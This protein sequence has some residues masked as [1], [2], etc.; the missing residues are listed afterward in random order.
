MIDRVTISPTPPAILGHSRSLLLLLIVVNGCWALFIGASSLLPESA[1]ALDGLNRAA[2]RVG[3]VLIPSL[4]Y[5]RNIE[6]GPWLDRLGLSS[7]HRQGILIGLA[8]SLIWLL[9]LLIYRWGS[10]QGALHTHLSI[11]T[12]LNFILGSPF[13]EELLYRRIVYREL[14]RTFSRWNA[15]LLSSFWFTLLHLSPWIGTHSPLEL[16]QHLGIIFVYG[17]VFALFYHRSQSLWGSLIPHW[18]N[19]AVSSLYPAV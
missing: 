18:L 11:G 8:A 7:H 6:R 5:L 3:V 1:T 2:I 12:W 13:A 16:L 9:P 15:M 10:N 14:A 19:N 4:I 17:L